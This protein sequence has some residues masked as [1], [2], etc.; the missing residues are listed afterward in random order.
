MPHP[1][2]LQKHRDTSS[3]AAYADVGWGD[4]RNGAVL[5]WYS[6]IPLTA[7]KGGGQDE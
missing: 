1:Q 2:A 6:R 3:A 7:F 5:N 4:S